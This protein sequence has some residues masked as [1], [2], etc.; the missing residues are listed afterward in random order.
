MNAYAAQSSRARVFSVL[1]IV[2]LMMSV[3]HVAAGSTQHYNEGLCLCHTHKN[4][5]P[6]C[7][8]FHILKALALPD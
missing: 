7:C 2:S 1:G 3:Y 6:T 5:E 4:V 8:P